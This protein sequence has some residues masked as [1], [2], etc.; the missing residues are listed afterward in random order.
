MFHY[1][2]AILHA[3][4]FLLQSPVTLTNTCT[5]YIHYLTESSFVVKIPFTKCPNVSFLLLKIFCYVFSLQSFKVYSVHKLLKKMLCTY[6]LNHSC[7]WPVS[8]ILHNTIPKDLSLF[9]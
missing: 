7:Y 8:A 2:I 6:L 9:S 3:K 4:S 5:V 1:K